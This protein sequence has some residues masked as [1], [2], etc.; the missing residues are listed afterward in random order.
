MNRLDRVRKDIIHLHETGKN[1][2]MKKWLLEGHVL[3][4]AKYAEEIAKKAEADI[5]ISVLA[6]L[7][8]DIA[9]C[10]EVYDEP[11]L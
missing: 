8:H 10:W 5:E 11:A 3:V 4:V 1:L 9:R 2:E 6:S 7:F